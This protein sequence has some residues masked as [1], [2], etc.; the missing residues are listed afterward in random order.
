MAQS[1]TF[2]YVDSLPN[3]WFYQPDVFA[4]RCYNGSAFTG[5]TDSTVVDSIAYHGDR[6]DQAVEVYFRPTATPTEILDQIQDLWNSGQ[7]E[8]PYM[9]LTKDV[10]APN[11]AEEWYTIDNILLVNF[12]DPYPDS[13]DLANFMTSLNLT[14]YHTPDPTLPTLSQGPSYTYAFIVNPVPDP[15]GSPYPAEYFAQI[16]RDA[17]TNFNGL[18]ANAEPNIVN[19]RYPSRDGSQSVGT[20]ITDISTYTCPTNDPEYPVLNHIEN[21]GTI[22]NI[23]NNQGPP[24]WL[25]AGTAG[26][27]AHICGCWS[28]GL[29][30]AGVTVG[31]IGIERHYINHPDMQ[32][33]YDVNKL[34]DCTTVPCTPA[35]NAWNAYS[36]GLSYDGPSA[37][38]AHILG[39]NGNDNYGTIG[40]A[41]EV[42][43]S[44]YQIASFSAGNSATFSTVSAISALQKALL[45]EDDIVIL[46]WFFDI[47]LSSLSTDIYN[48]YMQGR[49]GKRTILIAPAG[50]NNYDPIGT[51]IPM[52]PA[53]TQPWIHNPTN[54]IGVIGS[55]RYDLRCDREVNGGTGVA[56]ACATNYGDV[57]EIAAPGPSLP[58]VIEYPSCTG[59]AY[60]YH[61]A[62]PEKGAMATVAGVIAMLL[63]YDPNLTEPQIVSLITQGADKVGGYTYTNGVSMELGNGRINCEN[64]LNLLLTTSQNEQKGLGIQI[65][66][67][68]DGWNIR[69]K[70]GNELTATAIKLYDLGGN[71]IKSYDFT[72]NTLLILNK[73]LAKGIYLLSLTEKNKEESKAIKLFNY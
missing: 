43:V 23:P 41:P 53:A 17:F 45:L 73:S 33:R 68:P 11:T 38:I 52:Y 16:A 31:V 32:G 10:T 63:E 39:S 13:A 4:F 57:Y 3:V 49:N 55:N 25:P 15:I 14:S 6:R 20:S 61:D 47:Q 54:V 70:D 66:Y 40:V 62:Y 64:S 18:V 27:D 34:W 28:Q 8:M 24:Y 58:F 69:K 30:G 35:F 59:C 1:S 5:T 19:H 56:H 29:S 48:L 46:D 9:T 71:F 37:S 22:T 7:I 12:T 42:A 2:W 21:I 51:A 26:A 36:W 60:L 65:D 67:T 50:H 44:A 72:G